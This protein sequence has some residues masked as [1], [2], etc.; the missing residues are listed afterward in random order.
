M[1]TSNS[2]NLFFCEVAVN[3]PVGNGVLTYKHSRKLSRGDLIEVPLGR[4]KAKGCVL[5]A[6][7]SENDLSKT[8]RGYELKNIG[9]LIPESLP[10]TEKELSL[11]FWISNFYHY[12]LGQLIF[13]CLPKFLKRP[14]KA[15]IINGLDSEI[16]FDYTP[17]QMKALEKMEKNKSSTFYKEYLHGVTGSGKTAIYLSRIREVIKSGKS[18]LFLLPEINLTP[19]FVKTFSE[20]L[21][22]EVLS[23]HSGVNASQ[24]FHIWKKL[25]EESDPLFVMGVRSSVFLPINNLGLVIVDE[26]HDS[27]FKQSDRCPYNG[28]DVAI[29]K[30]QI[31][32][33]PII[34]GSATPSLENYDEF[35]KN[36]SHY[37]RLK[38]RISGAFPEIEIIDSGSCSPKDS[39]HWPI[40]NEAIDQ[41]REA[42][43]KGEQAIVFV[44]RLGYA[45]F[46]QC[47]GCGFKFTD[48]E[49]DTNLRYFKKRHILRSSHS[50]FSMPVPEICPECG[51][52]NLL[53][54]GY[55]TEKVQEVLQSHFPD[56][57]IA[58]FDRD[59]IKNFE[60]LKSTL[61]QFEKEEIDVLVGTQMLSKGH[62]FKRVNLVVVLGIDHQLNF[63]DFR[64]VERAYQLLVQV[65]G[66]AGRY[67]PNS[68]VLI[69]TVNPDSPFFETFKTNNIDLFFNQE[70]DIREATGFPPFSKIGTV[71]FT[72][73]N[74]LH[75]AEFAT[76][77]KEFMKKVASKNNLPVEILGPAPV[78]IEKRANQ[79]TWN[80]ICRAKDYQTLYLVLQKFNF[81][82]TKK[83]PMSV[84]ID[85]NPYFYC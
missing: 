70:L 18:V 8:A 75:V 65:S 9:E 43:S 57:R 20:F 53:Q 55:G 21:P 6:H 34:L 85:V 80:I 47:S 37:Y 32:E 74:R 15:E 46:I 50:E 51:N 60:D 27:S 1:S 79:F 68:K 3:F 7:M 76:K 48:P 30:A 19:Q 39:P 82:Q 71:F 45:N 58:R 52:M 73:G 84:K 81:S 24:K 16:P 28:R 12:S 63:P 49:T 23:Y 67:S 38:H 77:A 83:S 66:R 10:L 11:Y 44:S 35:Q 2:T 4:R 78:G 54:L 22:C 26:E 41:I 40:A 61:D 59:E 29:K 42:F 56:K 13:D 33:C 62:N 64:S 36:N 69:Q 31:S 25:K 17:E 72:G 14:R 5:K